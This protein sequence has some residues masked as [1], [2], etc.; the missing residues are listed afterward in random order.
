MHAFDD[1][2]AAMDANEADERLR[3]LRD[4]A[5][6]DSAAAA[7]SER[8]E[9]DERARQEETSGKRATSRLGIFAAFGAI[10]ALVEFLSTAHEEHELA[11]HR[12]VAFFGLDLASVGVVMLL[13]I[14]IARVMVNRGVARELDWLESLPFPVSTT[15]AHFRLM[16]DGYATVMVVFRETMPERDDFYRLLA[17]AN[18]NGLVVKFEKF[19]ATAHRIELH[20]KTEHDSS[21]R[22]QWRGWHV[23]VGDLLVPLHARHPIAGI[24]INR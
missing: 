22:K 23:V 6:K 8:T 10:M 4:N 2:I 19:D 18:G 21:A 3:A 1:T 11:M 7:V 5:A 9:R 20:T 14:L 17:G 15:Q 13:V 16:G 12:E 24:E